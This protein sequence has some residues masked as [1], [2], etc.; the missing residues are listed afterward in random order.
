MLSA[1]SGFITPE[2]IRRSRSEDGEVLLDVHRGQMFTINIVGSQILDFLQQGWDEFQIVAEVARAYEI[3]SEVA[4]ADVHE[5]IDALRKHNIV[6]S[7]DVSK[8]AN[9]DT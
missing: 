7:H 3:S 5:F 1:K 2:S 9:R 4:R 6:D 8:H